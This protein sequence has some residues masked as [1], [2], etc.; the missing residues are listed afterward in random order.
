MMAEIQQVIVFIVGMLI[1]LV[2]AYYVTHFIG[3]KATGQTRSSLKN[4]NIKI[5]DRYSIAKD[6]QFC[7]I[8]IAGT[9]YVMG[10]TNHGMT[11]LDTYDAKV[12]AELTEENK[13]EAISWNMTSVGKYGNKFTRKVVEFVAIKTGKKQQHDTKCGTVDDG[14]TDFASSFENAKRKNS[15][16]TDSGER[17]GHF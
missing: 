7:I 1:V 11:L 15:Q 14:N 9:V 3:M 2:G 16:S 5:I 10:V 6:K 17:D 12:F 4:R 8:E 13:E